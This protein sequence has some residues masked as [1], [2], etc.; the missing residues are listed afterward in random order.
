VP[1]DLTTKFLIL[2]ASTES[3]NGTFEIHVCFEVLG[4]HRVGDC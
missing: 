2:T 3:M 4:F 1:S